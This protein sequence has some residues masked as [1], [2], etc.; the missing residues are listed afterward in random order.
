MNDEIEDGVRAHADFIAE[1]RKAWPPGPWVDEPDRVEWRDEATGLPCLIVRGH[2][3]ALCG[4]VGVPEGHPWFGLDEHDP[5]IQ[6]DVHN[7][8]TYGDQCYKSS[9]VQMTSGDGPVWWFGFSCSNAN[10]LAPLLLAHIPSIAASQTYRNIDYVRQEVTS[11]AKQLAEVVKEMLRKSDE[12][13]RKMREAAKA[14]G[15]AWPSI[16]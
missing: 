5:A 4:Y 10:D 8:I 15:F 14:A 6:V 11:L 9:P 12:Q 16:E 2:L 3:G 13:L 7:G 1:E